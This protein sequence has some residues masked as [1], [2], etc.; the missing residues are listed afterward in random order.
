VARGEVGLAGEWSPGSFFLRWAGATALLADGAGSLW[1]GAIGVGGWGESHPIAIIGANTNV[2]T[3]AVIFISF[4]LG[5]P[6]RITALDCLKTHIRLAR[7]R[8]RF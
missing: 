5:H 6:R 2:I 8:R 3:H 7:H 4:S 1:A